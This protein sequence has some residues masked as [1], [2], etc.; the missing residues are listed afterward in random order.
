M[1]EQVLQAEVQAGRGDHEE[2]QPRQKSGTSS[3]SQARYR[4][5]YEQ[6]GYGTARQ[7]TIHTQNM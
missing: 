2:R 7:S 6:I 4:T 1:E 5:L 3:I